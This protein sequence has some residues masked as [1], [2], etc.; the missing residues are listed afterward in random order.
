M[1][2]K[3]KGVFSNKRDKLS[4]VKNLLKTAKQARVSHHRRLGTENTRKVIKIRGI[5]VETKSIMKLKDS[6]RFPH[7]KKKKNH[8]ASQI[9]KRVTRRVGEAMETIIWA[10]TQDKEMKK[11]SW[12]MRRV[13]FR[14]W[15]KSRIILRI[16]LKDIRGMDVLQR[17]TNR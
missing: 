12:I 10:D 9:K 14:L 17:L 7:R 4:L 3:I 2:L 8:K 5:I 1:Q 16:T 13:Y 11:N 15:M 6:N